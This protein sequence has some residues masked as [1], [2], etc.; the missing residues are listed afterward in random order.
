LAN[1]AKSAGFGSVSQLLE[2]QNEAVSRL[3]AWD[4][5][6]WVGRKRHCEQIFTRISKC[7]GNE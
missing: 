3:R 1:I 5:K 4:L 7:R 2:W 6:T